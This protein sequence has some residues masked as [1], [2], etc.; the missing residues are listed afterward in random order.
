MTLLKLSLRSRI[1][2]ALMNDSQT[3]KDLMINRGLLV[4]TKGYV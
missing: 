4:S 2:V 1:L 3:Y